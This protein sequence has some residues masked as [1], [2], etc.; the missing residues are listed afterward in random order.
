MK[1]PRVYFCAVFR[2]Q[3]CRKPF[4][5][6]ARRFIG[7]SNCQNIPRFRWMYRQDPSDSLAIF[8]LWTFFI[9]AQEIQFAFA[10]ICRNRFIQ[11]CIPVIKQIRNP[12]N[13]YRCLSASCACKNQKRSLYLKNCLA[14][15][16]VHSAK[17]VIQN[18]T[19][20]SRKIF[21]VICH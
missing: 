18:G 16:F 17:F 15:H 19:F 11:I 2:T 4:F 6:L 14:L 5:Q 12:V 10:D 13:Q 9:F 20:K 3:H 8:F 1:R 7:K 21:T